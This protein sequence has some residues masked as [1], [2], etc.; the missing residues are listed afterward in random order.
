MCKRS[1]G[2]FSPLILQDKIDIYHRWHAKYMTKVRATGVVL[3]DIRE[4]SKVV[5]ILAGA[6]NVTDL[7]LANWFL[8]Y[9]S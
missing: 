3:C 2:N 1:L 6:M 9:Q 5:G 7:V 4:V 8:W